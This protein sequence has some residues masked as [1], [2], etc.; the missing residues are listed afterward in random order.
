MLDNWCS[1]LDVV[2]HDK[3]INF[4]SLILKRKSQIF[5][6]IFY[7]P[8]QKFVLWRKCFW[9]I[10]TF[11][12]MIWLLKLLRH[13]GMVFSKDFKICGN[14]TI[15]NWYWARFLILKITKKWYMNIL[16]M[17]I[18]KLGINNG[19]LMPDVPKYEPCILILTELW[20]C[21]ELVPVFLSKCKKVTG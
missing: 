3:W 17:W 12:Q 13:Y 2:V 19:R 5:Q 20:I 6:M 14:R 10:S 21:N 16:C 9:K 18:C 15:S 8:S 4:E 7:F 1:R 11:L